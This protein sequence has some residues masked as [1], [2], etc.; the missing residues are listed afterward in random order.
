LEELNVFKRRNLSIL[1]VSSVACCRRALENV[2]TLFDPEASFPTEEP[3]PRP[4]LHADLLRIPSVTLND[5]WELEGSD[6]ESL[7]D[8]ILSLVANGLP[9]KAALS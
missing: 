2:W 1:I 8:G 4:L 5:Q 9:Q 7:V 6:Q 3:L